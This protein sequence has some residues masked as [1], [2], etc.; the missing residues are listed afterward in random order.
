MK[1]DSY[2]AHLTETNQSAEALQRATSVAGRYM[3]VDCYGFRSPGGRP[4]IGVLF[5]SR[6]FRE[7]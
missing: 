2:A 6:R 7:L 4:G 5:A 1:V 3:F